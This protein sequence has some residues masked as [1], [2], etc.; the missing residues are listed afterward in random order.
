VPEYLLEKE[1]KSRY[2][3]SGSRH[4]EDQR[5]K[6]S[7]VSWQHREEARR[8]DEEITKKIDA[9]D[10][11]LSDDNDEDNVESRNTIEERSIV[12]SIPEET[13]RV[14]RQVSRQRPGFFWTLAR[15]AFEVRIM[16]IYPAIGA[17]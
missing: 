14:V 7:D 16:T 13:K 5:E 6:Q 11:Y 2:G 8:K 4:V 1:Q 10:R 15:L 9:L 17:S 12:E 3:F